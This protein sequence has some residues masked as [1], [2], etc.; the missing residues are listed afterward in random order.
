MPPS[1]FKKSAPKKPRGGEE[2]TP[3]AQ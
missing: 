1:P 2:K 3:N